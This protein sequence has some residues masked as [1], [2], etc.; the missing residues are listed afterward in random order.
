MI[1]QDSVLAH[2][3][4]W[5]GTRWSGRGHFFDVLFGAHR[6]PQRLHGRRSISSTLP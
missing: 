5:S 3:L 6:T 1:A 4:A 2:S